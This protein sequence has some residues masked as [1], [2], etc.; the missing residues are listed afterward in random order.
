MGLCI[1]SMTTRSTCALHQHLSICRL[2]EALKSARGDISLA[3]RLHK[4]SVDVLA[5]RHNSH[6]QT[7]SLGQQYKKVRIP[8]S[9]AWLQLTE[10][11]ANVHHSQN[12]HPTVCRKLRLPE[13]QSVR[14]AS[15][16]QNSNANASSCQRQGKPLLHGLEA[17]G[18]P[19]N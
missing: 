12:P 19:F 1:A 3:P 4:T 14:G 7:F 8:V 16:Q 18:V 9:A 10:M 6:S 17:C 11:G 5:A 2:S 15:D 13:K